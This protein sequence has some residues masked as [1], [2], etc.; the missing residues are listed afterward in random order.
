MKKKFLLL[1]VVILGFMLELQAAPVLPEASARDYLKNGALVIDVRTVE[2]FQ[3]GH[4]TNVINIPLNELK[5][6]LPRQVSDKGKVL[7][8]HCQSGRRSGIAEAQLRAMGYTNSFS[9]GSF[10]QA[11]KILTGGA[12]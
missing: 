4:L 11:R 2:E 8:L 5:E 3:A 12:R 6:K 7:L 9:I 1:T 10:E